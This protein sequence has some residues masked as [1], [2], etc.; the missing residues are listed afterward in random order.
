MHKLTL[1]DFLTRH[2]QNAWGEPLYLV[3]K[4]LVNICFTDSEHF[5]LHLKMDQNPNE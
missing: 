2:I 5:F 4:I 3:R 1:F